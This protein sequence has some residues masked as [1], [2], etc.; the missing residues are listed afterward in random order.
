MW[1]VA[2]LL[3]VGVGTAGWAS[4][5]PVTS[6]DPTSTDGQAILKPAL[7]DLTTQLGKPAKLDVKTLNVSQGWAYVNGFIKAPDGQWIDYTGTPFEVGSH[8]KRYV[9][10]LRDGGQG[11]SLVTS[12]VGPS[13]VAWANWGEEYGAPAGVVPRT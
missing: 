11:W 8:S 2:L 3:C 9:A 6:P 7:A 1:L 4:A 5:D 13:D 10:L 12:R